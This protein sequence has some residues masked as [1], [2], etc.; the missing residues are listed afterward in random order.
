[1]TYYLAGPMTGLP[2][3]NFNAFTAACAALRER[4]LSVVSPHEKDPEL[5]TRGTWEACL[6]ADIAILM[7]DCHA[8]I[9]LPGWS[10]SKGATLELTYRTGAQDAG[11]LL[12]QRCAG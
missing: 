5:E 10:N 8:M 7:R 9:L 6:R 12:R 4:G 1:M 11:L 2:D 3:F